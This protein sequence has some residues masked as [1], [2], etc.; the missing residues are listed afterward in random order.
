MNFKKKLFNFLDSAKSNNIISSS[1]F[2]ELENFYYKTSQNK[3]DK[4]FF[5]FINI[6]IM[7]GVFLISLGVVLVTCRNW[8]AIDNNTK[9]IMYFLIFALILL[10]R[11]PRINYYL[12]AFLSFYIL[13]GI[14]L[15][16]HINNITFK[17]EADVLGIW[18]LF[19]A[20]L[21]I[22]LNH[23]IITL[24]AVFSAAFWFVASCSHDYFFNPAPLVLISGLIAILPSINNFFAHHFANR[25]ITT[26]IFFYLSLSY[27][28]FQLQFGYKYIKT[29]ISNDNIN[30]MIP[31][32]I[33]Q[34]FVLFKIIRQ[35]L[36]QN[37]YQKYYYLS[38]ITISIFYF[39]TYVFQIE[40]TTELMPFL[41]MI[42][43]IFIALITFL[44]FCSDYKLQQYCYQISLFSLLLIL[45]AA[46]N[47]TYAP[48]YISSIVFFISATNQLQ[49]KRIYDILTVFAIYLASFNN[50][51]CDCLKCWFVFAFAI[52]NAI[53]AI[54]FIKQKKANIIHC[55]IFF[56]INLL[57]IFDKLP[58]INFLYFLMT[59]AISLLFIYEGIIAKDSKKVN[60]FI[61]IMFLS[62]FIKFIHI[63]RDHLNNG[64][65]YIF[66]GLF[67]IVSACFMQKISKNKILITNN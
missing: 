36:D 29:E 60:I 26:S 8:A 42:N 50:Y 53:V 30:I 63:N 25:K 15:I 44:L 45:I 52:I 6:I 9:I 27:W 10:L 35:G 31:V 40:L 37:R 43:I 18:A 16:C 34:L 57:L 67:F 41:I 38:V 28:F 17:K 20:P 61:W 32:L 54:Y 19:I 58:F 66:I 3:K 2:I 23:K 48:I 4:S 46:E 33:M 1:N 49:S 14:V 12:D 59:I 22:I 47:K 55:A 39:L 62:V 11:R 56:L 7:L 64:F 21:A 13:I 24:M 51:I 5:S 65:G